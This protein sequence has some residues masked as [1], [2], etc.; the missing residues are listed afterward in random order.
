MFNGKD[1]SGWQVVLTPDVKGV[2][3]T[4]VFQV[5]D[6][7]IHAYQDV[8]QG[9]KVPLGFIATDD[10][11]SWYHLKL[12]YR[13]VGK[14]FAPRVDRV[15]DAGALYHAGAENKVW[16]RCIECQIQEGDV[17]DC[18]IVNGAQLE[19]TVDPRLLKSDVRKYLP[20]K[21]GG[22]VDVSG[23]PSI[24]R[25]IKSSTHELDDWNTVEVIVRG[26]E[27]AVHI[28][29]GHEVFRAKKLKQ[30]DSDTQTWIPLTSGRIL[31]QAEFAE[32]L[33]R[34]VQIK[35]LEGGPFRVANQAK[36]TE[37]TSSK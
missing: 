26:D 29:N 11:Y 13:W 3:S 1:L 20:A 16:P 35:P 27:E 15:R 21:D 22:V 31:L 25:I 4:K 37:N 2:D 6:G 33:Y 28:V 17:G 14:R 30:F 18:F 7:L 34:N 5:H 23:G 12:E 36:P 24:Y 9:A 32:V 19:S 8:P 10:N